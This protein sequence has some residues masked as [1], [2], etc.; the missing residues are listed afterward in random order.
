MESQITSTILMVRPAHFGYN[1]QTAND[2]AFQ[3]KSAD[4]SETEISAKAVQEFDAFV[5]KLEEA[6]VEVLVVEDTEQPVKPD[7]IFPNNWITTH[8]DG[9]IVTYPM[10]APVRRLE[11]RADILNQLEQNFRVKETLHLEDKESENLFLEGTGS[12]ILDRRHRLVYAC[13][14]E[15]TSEELLEIFAMKVGYQMILFDAADAAGK[16][17]Y[18]TNVL[19]ALGKDLVVI[20][21]DAIRDEDSRSNL[22]DAFD[23]SGKMVVDISFDQMGA[24][25]GN[26]LQVENKAG[27]P[28]LVMSEQAYS[29]L[30]SDQ[31][32]DIQSRSAILYSPINTIET[33][34]GGSARC[35][36][37]EIFLE[38]K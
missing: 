11:R 17:I 18:H 31:I 29:S 21:L 30:R 6:G 28:I 37:A 15:R 32:E 16:P 23:R 27:E 34:G 8:Q 2:N 22:L 9:T 38:K 10:Y 12:M 25:A 26:M 24:F 5:A 20:C 36:M 33:T 14:S 3:T 1:E 19:M 13:R 4:Q 35:M 7:A